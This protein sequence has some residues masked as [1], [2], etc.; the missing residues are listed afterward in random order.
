MD[1]GG[2]QLSTQMELD[3][4]VR[5]N[6]LRTL[7]KCVLPSI[8]HGSRQ[9]S[10]A[11]LKAVLRGLDD[12]IGSGVEYRVSL[13]R[14]C[15][16]SGRSRGTVSAALAGLASMSLIDVRDNFEVLDGRASQTFSTYRIFW[17]NVTDF[18]PAAPLQQQTARAPQSVSV[19]RR[20]GQ[21]TE[22]GGLS[23]RRGGSQSE[24]L[25]APSRPLTANTPPTSAP[26][27]SRGKVFGT[28]FNN[29]TLTQAVAR[30]DLKPIQR[31]FAETA[32]S[33]T[34][35]AGVADDLR[36]FAATCYDVRDA[37]SPVGV[38]AYRVRESAITREA[39]SE[40]AWKWA[41]KLLGQT[42]S[43]QPTQPADCW[44]CATRGHH[45]PTCDVCGTKP[46]SAPVRGSRVGERQVA[47]G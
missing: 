39:V 46:H 30:V 33:E 23:L 10:G 12:C 15:E 9:T 2:I 14:L 26:P 44:L 41:G 18:V 43:N 21:R 47:H 22:M 13:A 17:S 20:I 29:E 16:Q 1:H 25:T 24:T 28:W 38:L 19:T 7:A 8:T 35:S 4:S 37:K 32:L 5:G 40:S 31:A 36:A 34:Q 42:P 27:V 6:Q 3:W 11:S 45:E